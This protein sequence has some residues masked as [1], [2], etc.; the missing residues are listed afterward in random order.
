MHECTNAD[1]AVAGLGEPSNQPVTAQGVSLQPPVKGLSERVQL[2]VVIGN[3]GYITNP[4]TNP[5][6]DAKDV[7]LRLGELGFEVL[8]RVAGTFQW[9]EASNT[10]V[11]ILDATDEDVET[12]VEMVSDRIGNAIG[13]QVIVFWFYSGHGLE[14]ASVP[15]MVP[16]EPSGQVDYFD[17]LQTT[18]DLAAEM[19]DK[20]SSVYGISRTLAAYSSNNLHSI[21]VLDMCR[22]HPVTGTSSDGLLRGDPQLH[23]SVAILYGCSA[24]QHSQDAGSTGQHGVLTGLL[25]QELRNGRTFRDVFDRVSEAAGTDAQQ[26]Q[27]LQL[28]KHMGTH[29]MPHFSVPHL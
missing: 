11:S 25:L 29:G 17:S 16:V 6:N 12:L 4:L 14:A 9:Q 15:Y 22:D 8:G 10:V 7:A 3:S 5:P 21:F 26:P 24:G 20:L 18:S 13:R 27:L 19:N 2:A 28:V 23:D 1:A